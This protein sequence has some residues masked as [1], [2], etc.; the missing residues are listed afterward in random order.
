[1]Q[2]LS[3]IRHARLVDY[4][5]APATTATTVL[6]LDVASPSPS[7]PS[8]PPTSWTINTPLLCRAPGADGSVI[9]FEIED[10]AAGITGPISFTADV[11]WNRASLTP[12]YW[13]DSQR[14]LLAGSADFY[15][16]E[17]D[18]GLYCGQQLLLD[19][20]AASSA[21]PPARELVEISAVAQ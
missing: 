1:T 9:N 8:P 7:P 18:T 13:D 11:R 6:Q 16:T 17:W 5:P 2:R 3:V 20:P 4:E 19:S 10:P 14:C 21:D 12:Y 15:I